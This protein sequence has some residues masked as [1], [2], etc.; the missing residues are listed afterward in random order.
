MALVEDTNTARLN[1]LP[2]DSHSFLA[3]DKLNRNMDEHENEKSRQAL[4]DSRIPDHL[5]LK[6]GAKVMLTKN[7]DP[8]VNGSMGVVMGFSTYRE[9]GRALGW[10]ET[11]EPPDADMRQYP[12]V[13]FDGTETS[14]LIVPLAFVIKEDLAGRAMA[15]R[16]QVRS[17]AVECLR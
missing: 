7:S 6:V 13:L 4:R 1:A 14:E 15:T 12:L 17:P 8:L 9:H 16:V 10:A 11:K 5:D 3:R 2:G